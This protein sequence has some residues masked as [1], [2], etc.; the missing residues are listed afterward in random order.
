MDRSV[1][2]LGQVPVYQIS[3]PYTLALEAWHEREL[4]EIS[5]KQHRSLS[6][7][8]GTIAKGK[9][10]LFADPASWMCDPLC[11]RQV[12]GVSLYKDKDHISRTGS[13]RYAGELGAALDRMRQSDVAPRSAAGSPK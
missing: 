9:G 10:A 11:I 7:D 1:L 2:V 8:V 12:D 4:G 3:V 13:L 5:I 6:P